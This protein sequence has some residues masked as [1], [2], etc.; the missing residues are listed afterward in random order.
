MKQDLTEF[1]HEQASAVSTTITQKPVPNLLPRITNTQYRIAVIGE[2]PGNDE[3][4]QGKPFVGY[5][6]QELDRLLSR[7]SILRDACF[8]GNISQ[9]R[10][11]K[12]QITNFEWDGPEIQSGL[13]QLKEDLAKVKPNI[14][15][16]LGST[17]LHAFKSNEPLKKHKTK[18]G[19]KFIYPNPISRWRGSFFTSIPSSPLPGVK[20]IASYHPAA[21]LRN[22]EWTPVL[23]FDIK[24]CYEDATFPEWNPPERTL[25]YN[26]SFN[27]TLE[28]LQKI[29]D[30]KTLVATDIEGGLGNMSCISFAT[31]PNYGFIVP[32][33]RMD[34]SSYWCVDEEV[35][36]WKYLARVLC[37]PTIPKVLQNGAYDRFVLQYGYQLVVK[38][39]TEGT[40]LKHWEIYAEMKKSLAFMASIYTKEPYWKEMR[41][42]AEQEM[43]E[44]EE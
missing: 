14:C 15:L 12:N 43:E 22:Y 2:A 31:S 23:M 20:C 11:E 24:R 16:L 18:E 41:I 30:T 39:V 38:G 7:F 28:E 19:Y 34:G 8:L 6:G 42:Q 37:D 40:D 25:K 29:I 1:F 21:C 33:S 5:S 10:P 3:V 4:D 35:I 17:A 32:F 26:L 44:V 9:Y 36:I 13:A 27:E